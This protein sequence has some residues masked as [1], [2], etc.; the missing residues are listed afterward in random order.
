MKKQDSEKRIRNKLP[1]MIAALMDL[2]NQKCKVYDDVILP[3]EPQ[4]KGNAV[5][6]LF[7]PKSLYAISKH[8]YSN[9]ISREIRLNL[10]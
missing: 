7:D 4:S 6:K 1:N 9:K 5:Y 3:K 2:R 8:R 10:R